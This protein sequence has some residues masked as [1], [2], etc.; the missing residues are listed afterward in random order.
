MRKFP[1]TIG[2]IKSTTIYQYIYWKIYWKRFYG[3]LIKKLEESGKGCESDHG[4]P[5]KNKPGIAFSFDDSFRVNHWE[6][7]GKELFGYYDVKVTFNINA[8]HH[9]EG[10]RE[11]TQKEIDMLLELQSNGHE[12]AHHGFNHQRA[13]QYS[14][15]NGLSKWV[16]D[17]IETMLDWM[18]KQKHSKTNEKFKKPV[19]F[20][21]PF[22]VSNEETIKELVPE[23]FKIV[24]GQ[25]SEDYLLPSNHTGFAPSFCVDKTF[26][27]NTKYIKKIMRAA[28][29][30]GSNLIFMC[31]SILPEN[32][33]WDEFGWGNES[34]AAGEWRTSPHVIQEIINEARK[35]GMEFYTT[36]EIAGVAT[37]IDQNLENCIREKIS[38]PLERWISISELGKIK[39]LDLSNKYISNLDGIQYLTNLERLYLTN[40]NITDFRLLE[41]LRKLKVINISNNP[42]SPISSNSLLAKKIL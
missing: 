28:K 29:Q 41:R 4:L 42:N 11:H 2:Q 26:L 33:N 23:Y 24:R 30:V 35:I 21:F 15:E 20:A 9:F 17:E 27:P 18:K 40:N 31:H 14:R 10:N 25:F 8:F 39:E 13:V 38:N 6:K 19:S 37:F 34:R 32:I 3:E 5:F 22:T 12:I 1:T 16:E 7:Y 36:S